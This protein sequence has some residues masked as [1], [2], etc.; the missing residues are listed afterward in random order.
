MKKGKG[1]QSRVLGFLLP[2]FSTKNLRHY[3]RSILQLMFCVG[4]LAALSVEHARAQTEKIFFGN[5]HSHT[6]F[7]D[8]S[9]KPADA[10]THARGV[11]HLDFLAITEHNHPECENGASSDRKDGI[12]IG[13]DPKLYKGPGTTALIPVANQFTENGRFV[14]IYGQEFSTVSQGNHV[15]VFE[16]GE[17][18]NVE[19][20]KDHTLANDWLVSHLDSTGQPAIIELNHPK[21]CENTC[22]GREY[23]K[24]DFGSP[25][26]WVRRMDHYTRLIDIVNGP[27]LNKNTSGGQGERMEEGFIRYLNLGFHLAPAADQ[28]NH[29][30]NWGTITD[31]RTAVIT[32]ELTKAKVLEA[33]RNRHV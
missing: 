4:F 13:K 8:G 6:S 14:A 29:Y 27:G 24:D 33:L 17:V 15:N 30:K 5:L 1:E 26:E 18:I 12:M 21:N 19:K 9:G 31:A 23:G 7:S 16:V 28:D 11:A 10:Y 3:T 2:E 20:G 25:A 22:V 32:D